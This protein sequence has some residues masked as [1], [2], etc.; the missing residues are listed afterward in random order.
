MR[1]QDLSVTI[2]RFYIYD[3]C[4]YWHLLNMQKKLKM[5]TGAS[6]KPAVKADAVKACIELET[7]K[8]DLKGINPHLVYKPT[9][10]HFRPF[11]KKVA[12]VPKETLPDIDFKAMEKVH[13][14]KIVAVH[15]AYMLRQ[16]QAAKEAEEKKKLAEAERKKKFDD[17]WNNVDPA[18]ILAVLNCHEKKP[19]TDKL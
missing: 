15:R 13:A 17:L 6:T 12:A 2:F 9:V 11:A 1:V 4:W 18:K 16:A 19:V 5:R 8:D 10:N 14:E 7:E 3:E